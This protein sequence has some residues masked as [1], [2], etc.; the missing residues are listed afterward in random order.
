MN[1]YHLHMNM[2]K[3]HDG[4]WVCHGGSWQFH[5]GCSCLWVSVHHVHDEQDEGGGWDNRA[6]G[7][8]RVLGGG[9][10]VWGWRELEKQ[11]RIKEEREKEREERERK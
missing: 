4:F 6:K 3:I 10:S 7:G 11:E 9:Q 1:I 2:M 5:G 8:V